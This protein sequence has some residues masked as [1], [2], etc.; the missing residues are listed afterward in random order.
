[1]PHKSSSQRLVQTTMDLND[2]EASRPEGALRRSL[3]ACVS[4]VIK[5]GVGARK[6]PFANVRRKSL[7]RKRTFKPMWRRTLPCLKQQLRS[8]AYCTVRFAGLQA[9]PGTLFFQHS[10]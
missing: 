9:D 10:N 8:P 4:A 1:M 7:R 6:D 3:S 5:F 2:G